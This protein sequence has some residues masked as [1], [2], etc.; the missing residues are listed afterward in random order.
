[1]KLFIA[2]ISYKTAPVE[3]REQIAVAPGKL[4]C[5]GCRLKVAGALSETVVLS[6]CNRVEIYGVAEKV[7]GNIP[8]LFKLLRAPKAGEPAQGTGRELDLEPYLYVHEEEDAVKHLLSVVSGMDSMVIGETEI[9][10]QVK[11]AY[12]AAQSA[13]LTGRVLNRVFQ[14]ALQT[15]KAVRTRTGLGRGATSVGSVSL[16]MAEKIF[17][18][19]LSQKTVMIVGAGKMGEACIRHLTKRGVKSVLVSNRSYERA[20]ALAK[21]FGG[22][23]VRLEDCLPAMAEADIVVSSTGA[24]EIILHRADIEKV[25]RG[26]GNRPLAM[27]D[28][29]VPRDIDPEVQMI[30]GVYLYDIDDLESIVRENVRH[31][32]QELNQCRAIIEEETAEVMAKIRPIPEKSYDVRIQSK[33]GWLFCGPVACHS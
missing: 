23:A 33:P 27:I 3:L 15:A 24:P 19:D 9:T 30:P 10:G 14:K 20:Q 6:T 26:R 17:G 28:I 16:E 12:Q 11:Q 2:G 4:S 18:G 25:M 1:M 21:E 5:A 31:R 29:A 22:R 7:N 32:E 8:P 13:K